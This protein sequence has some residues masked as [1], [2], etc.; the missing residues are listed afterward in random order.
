MCVC[1]CFK[2]FSKPSSTISS[3]SSFFPSCMYVRLCVS[4][5]KGFTS[6]FVFPS[7]F[8]S[9]LFTCSK[10][11]SPFQSLQVHRLLKEPSFC[12]DVPSVTSLSSLHSSAA[13]SCLCSLAFF[14]FCFFFFSPR[15]KKDLFARAKTPRAGIASRN[16]KKGWLPDSESSDA[17]QPGEKKRR[18]S[19]VHVLVTSRTN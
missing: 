12:V 18:L 1:V 15:K 17:L 16:P 6:F 5:S 4:T 11:F 10:L 3:F 14:F 2:F 13:A 9:L 7:F 19:A 8:Y